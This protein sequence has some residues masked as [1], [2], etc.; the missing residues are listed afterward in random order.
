MLRKILVP[1]DG[2]QTSEKALSWMR[3]VIAREKAQVILL[4]AASLEDFGDEYVH[5]ELRH[6]NEY[7]DRVGKELSSAGI[8][9]K[10]VAK[11]GD[12]ARLIVQV[13]EREACDLVLMTTRGGSKIK[14]WAVGGVAEKV[15]R[16]SSVP[17]LILRNGGA[18]NRKGR[19][20]R[21]IIPV[22]GSKLGEASVPWTARL[23]GL[24]K[25]E[26]VFL[27]VY[28]TG[29]VGLLLW[30]QEKFEAIDRRMTQ[31]CRDLKAKGRRAAFRVQSGDPADRILAFAGPSDLIVTTTHG[32]GGFKRWAFGSVAEKLI[33]NGSV[34]VLVYK[35]LKPA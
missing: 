2:S 4:R 34:P 31:L 20:R 24:L 33:H 35:N 13:A 8:P 25:A 21:I 14:R 30:H 16:L 22:D 28:P 11:V 10:I 23:A 15:L 7:L 12:P 1:L 32:A 3:Q 18:P 27:H 29:P 9:I 5:V 6:A 17:V 26:I 19:V